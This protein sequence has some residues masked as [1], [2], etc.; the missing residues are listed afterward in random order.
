MFFRIKDRYQR[1]RF[2]LQCRDIFRTPPLLMRD[3]ELT[4]ISQVSHRDLAMYLI[5]VKSMYRFFSAGKIVV[6]DDGTLTERDRAQLKLHLPFVRFFS[7][8]AISSVNTPKGGC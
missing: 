6:L 4:F 8:A 3:A 1:M 2:N 5:A 7:C